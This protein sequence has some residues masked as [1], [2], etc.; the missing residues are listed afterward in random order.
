MLLDRHYRS[1]RNAVLSREGGQ[2]LSSLIRWE[3][4]RAAEYPGG[5]YKKQEQLLLQ[6]G[7]VDMDFED[8]I[9]NKANYGKI[10]EYFKNRNTFSM[11]DLSILVD[12]I[13]QMSPEIYEHYRALQDIFRREVRAA[14]NRGETDRRLAK[15]IKHGCD[16]GTLLAEK[17]EAYI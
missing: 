5:S 15:L 12:M 4:G 17:Y 13:E 16:N 8:L 6:Y 9:K 14:L 2:V 3:N 7:M 11:D 1:R 10:T